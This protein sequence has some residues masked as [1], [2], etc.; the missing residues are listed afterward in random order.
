MLHERQVAAEILGLPLEQV[1]VEIGDTALPEGPYSGAALATASFTPAVEAAAHEMRTR[2]LQLAATLLDSTAEELSLRA[3]GVCTRDGRHQ[4]S[5]PQLL[6]HTGNT[7]GL[8]ATA[9]ANAPGEAPGEQQYSSY[10]L[11]AVFAEVRVDADLGTVRVTRLTAAFAAGRILNPLLARSQYVG[12]LIGGIGLALHEQTLMDRRTG[13]IINDNLSDYSIP[14]HADMPHIDVHM[15][16]EVDPHLGSGIKGIGMLGTIGTAGAITNAIYHATGRRIRSLP[17]R[18][19][20][21][22]M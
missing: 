12:G 18:P 7:A 6:A 22:L 4:Q 10:G 13:H 2:L 19:E 9:R 5:L 8:E 3:S 11:G 16:E 20:Q 1:T 15:I 17:V 21:L 14:V